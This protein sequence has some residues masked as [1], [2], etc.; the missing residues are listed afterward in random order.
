VAVVT[1]SRPGREESVTSAAGSAQEFA[2]YPSLA[3]KVVFISGGASGLGAEFVEQ[4]ARQGAT[5][6]FAD[7]DDAAADVLADRLVALGL[8]RPLYRHADVRDLTAYQAVLADI[9]D[10]VGP[11]AVLVNNA[12]NDERHDTSVI[13][14]TRWTELLAVNLGHHLFAIQAV[15]PGMRGLGG[16]SI[17]NLGSVA[18]HA[19]FTG[20]PAYIAAKA[21]VEGLTRTLARE[22]GPDR[23]RVNCVIPGWVMTER[24]LRERVTPDAERILDES[25]CLPGRLVPADIARLVLWLGAADSAMCTGQNW[26]ADAGWS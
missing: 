26:V 19:P 7:I 9:A 18:A 13:D 22:L 15:A 3:G 16:G 4:F 2:S 23:I 17:I 5:V 12:A 21:G 8:E 11:V 14:P 25:Q 10:A 6:A 24:Q 20:M 1:S